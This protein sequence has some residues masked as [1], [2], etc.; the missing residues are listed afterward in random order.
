AI[1][2]HIHVAPPPVIISQP[3]EPTHQRVA[4]CGPQGIPRG[5]NAVDQEVRSI[6]LPRSAIISVG[7]LVLPEVMVGITDASI[8]RSPA[9]PRTRNCASTTAV[10]SSARPILQVP[11]GWK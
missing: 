3:L 5:R 6:R 7:A 8:T 1:F 10:A 4:T 2:K 9:M 11:T